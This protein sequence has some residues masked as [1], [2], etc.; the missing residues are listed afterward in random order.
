MRFRES[1]TKKRAT[2]KRKGK[3][4]EGCLA[5]STNQKIPEKKKTSR[6]PRWVATPAVERMRKRGTTEKG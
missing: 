3:K 2:R 1:Q 5:V 4:E 6:G